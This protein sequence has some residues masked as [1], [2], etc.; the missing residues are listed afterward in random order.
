MKVDREQNSTVP[1]VC[2]WK[3]GVCPGCKVKNRFIEGLSWPGPLFTYEPLKTKFKAS[4]EF[5][6]SQGQGCVPHVP[7]P[8]YMPGA[9]CTL[10]HS[11]P[12]S[13]VSVPA[14]YDCELLQDTCTLSLIHFRAHES[15]SF[16][17]RSVP[18]NPTIEQ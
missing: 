13:L 5:F 1:A 4:L 16:G 10:R 14:L 8:L 3:F 12:S 6:I 11:I 2:G 7:R 9:L 17:L 15:L 18:L